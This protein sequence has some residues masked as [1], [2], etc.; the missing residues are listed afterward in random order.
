[1]IGAVRIM[2]VQERR[3]RPALVPTQRPRTTAS[4]GL[5]LT[6]SIRGNPILQGAASCAHRGKMLAKSI[7]SVLLLKARR[8]SPHILG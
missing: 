8:P 6:V 2:I 5:V 4:E 1:M 7:V 3:S